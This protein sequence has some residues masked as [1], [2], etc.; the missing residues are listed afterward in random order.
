M[1]TEALALGF[2]VRDTVRPNR[3]GRHRTRDY[4]LH[5]QYYGLRRPTTK[6]QARSVH[7]HDLIVFK[8]NQ[9]YTQ[10]RTTWADEDVA[11]SEAFQPYGPDRVFV[12][13][14][15]AEDG[16]KKAIFELGEREKLGFTVNS[17]LPTCIFGRIIGTPSETRWIPKQFLKAGWLASAGYGQWFVNMTDVAHLQL[18][19]AF[20][21]TI[22][23]E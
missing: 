23:N 6:R 15:A 14:K 12:N 17:V 2:S 9:H 11:A 18:A 16:A 4:R 19:A 5:A 21:A 1:I 22:T 7:R 20:D 10:D 13:Y 3:P 8:P